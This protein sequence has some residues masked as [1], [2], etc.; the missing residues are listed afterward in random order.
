MNSL[1]N[2]LPFAWRA[3]ALEGLVLRHPG[4]HVPTPAGREPALW[5]ASMDAIVNR[6]FATYGE[7]RASLQADGGHLFPCTRH[8]FVTL[9]EGV[10]ELGLD[11]DDP[12]WA[13]IGFDSVR[14]SDADARARL[15]GTRQLV[16]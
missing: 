6:W 4:I 5:V 8:Y 14:P 1:P 2:K 12:D 15:E 16:T 9:R 10:R 13:R 11:P 7:A 3:P